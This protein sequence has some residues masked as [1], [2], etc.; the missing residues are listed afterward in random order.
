MRAAPIDSLSAWLDQKWECTDRL[1]DNESGAAWALFML[2]SDSFVM[3]LLSVETRRAYC[4]IPQ[5][6]KG[7]QE[8]IGL[9]KRFPGQIKEVGI[10]ESVTGE[11]EKEE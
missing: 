3:L 9:T 5:G 11:H 7:K 8:L 2:R 6:W 4:M 1:R 10:L